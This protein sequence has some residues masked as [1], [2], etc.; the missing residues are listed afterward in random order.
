MTSYF[1]HFAFHLVLI[2]LNLGII[3]ESPCNLQVV[4]KLRISD[5]DGV[6]NLKV[7][8]PSVP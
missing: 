1:T 6:H 5:V 2:S 7:Y 8:S 3:M 4:F